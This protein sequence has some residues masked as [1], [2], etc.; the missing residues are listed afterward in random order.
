MDA[1]TPLEGMRIVS[2]CHWLQGPAALQYLADLGADVVRI[3]PPH[4]GFERQWS[5]AGTRV[6]GVSTMYLAGNR[7]VRSIAVDLKATDGVE[8]AWRLIAR[9]HVVAENF[10][11][12]VLD[13]IGLGY[14]A[15]RARH[16]SIIYASAT[17]YGQGP[18]R[19]RPGQDLLLQA[20]TGVMAG[21]G[22][23][24]QPTPVGNAAVDQH[25]ATVF[26]LGILAAYVRQ[27]RTGEGCRVEA[28]LYTAA[29]DL[30][31]EALTH[32]AS[33][34]HSR[35][36]FIRDRHLA[37]WYNEAPYGVYALADAHVAVSLNPLARLAAALGDAPLAALAAADPFARRDECAAAVAAA[38]RGRRYADVEA[39]FERHGIWYERVR[40]FDDVL[41]DPQAAYADV[42]RRV[43]VRDAAATLV[44]HPVRYDGG[45]PPLRH[46]A[47]DPGEDTRG[48]L[49][50]AGYAD[51]E[52][53]RLV[54]SR[55]VVAAGAAA[56]AHT[57]RVDR[58]VP[59]H[60]EVD[61]P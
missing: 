28:S 6:A 1:T 3:E 52:I 13:R 57:E 38:L 20:R 25:G 51:A 32:Y 24:G 8:V 35:E 44:N 39:A 18:L 55:A 36:K 41:A 12:G 11:P 46:L 48:V 5:G 29:I 17:G 15:V 37:N 22:V 26:A 2:F 7:N 43:P 42:F 45:V 23:S 58:R 16:P 14:D 61:T 34:G 27:Q 53:E 59:P 47:V 30:V 21:T 50:E 54:A 56:A 31:S 4:G 10:R 9:A 49:R 60:R 40:D 19:D 33:G